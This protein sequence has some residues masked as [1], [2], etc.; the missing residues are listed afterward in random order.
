VVSVTPVLRKKRRVAA[1]IIRFS[2]PVDA[3]LA[4]SVAE[5]RLAIA[6]KKGSFD[7]KNAR[8]IPLKSAIYDDA[9]FT[10]TLIPAKPFVPRKPVGVRVGGQAHPGI[11]DSFGRFIAGGHAGTL[12]ADVKTIRSRGK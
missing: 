2:G 4:A 8:V 10:V 6:G 12:D 11:Y 3:A 7:A 9:T 5:Y 1:V